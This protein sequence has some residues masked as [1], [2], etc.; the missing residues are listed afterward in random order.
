MTEIMEGTLW[1]WQGYL[2]GEAADNSIFPVSPQRACQR[3]NHW[4][5][6]WH[7]FLILNVLTPSSLAIFKTETRTSM[8]PPLPSLPHSLRSWELWACAGPS[9]PSPALKRDMLSPAHLHKDVA[10]QNGKLL[11]FSVGHAHFKERHQALTLTLTWCVLPSPYPSFCGG[12][13]ERQRG[14]FS[15]TLSRAC[16]WP[17]L[18]RPGNSTKSQDPWLLLSLPTAL[19]WQWDMLLYLYLY[20]YLI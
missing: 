10:R 12:H 14:V 7:H 1:C 8:S 3:P 13:H 4:G 20:L 16:S 2:H 19:T 18:H 9:L 15:I 6:H 17:Y 5:H 11:E